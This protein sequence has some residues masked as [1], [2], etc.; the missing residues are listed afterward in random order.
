MSNTFFG[1]I[2]SP[3]DTVAVSLN[4]T[5]VNQVIKEKILQL[6]CE[7][8]TM[9]IRYPTKYRRAC[10]VTV[11]AFYYPWKDQFNRVLSLSSRNKSI[12]FRYRILTYLM[13]TW[14]IG[15]FHSESP[16]TISGAH[17]EKKY[18]T[19]SFFSRDIQFE[20]TLTNTR[21]RWFRREEPKVH[22]CTQHILWSLLTATYLTKI[23]PTSK[24]QP[25]HSVK[26]WGGFEPKTQR[27]S[28][29]SLLNMENL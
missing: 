9:K 10:Q 7:L 6:Y 14:Y 17:F 4:T 19:F 3:N 24:P 16:N 1:F 12:S 5:A 28:S 11:E 25:Q 2:K 13:L 20:F 26:W 21:L 29:I 15:L 27:F 22:P 18:P 8:K 23:V